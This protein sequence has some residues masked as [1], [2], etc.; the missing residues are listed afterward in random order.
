LQEPDDKEQDYY[1]HY[2][3]LLEMREMVNGATDDAI[4]QKLVMEKAEKDREIDQ[5][6]RE[7]AASKEREAKLQ[8]LDTKQQA[9][10]SRTSLKFTKS[11]PV[12]HK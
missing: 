6:R 10:S 3:R 5:L 12:N 7:L 9:N 11:P 4:I 1:L 8:K 2:I